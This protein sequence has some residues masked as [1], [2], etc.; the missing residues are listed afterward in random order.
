MSDDRVDPIDP[1]LYRHDDV[2]RI[3]AGWDI[4]A[5]FRFL[6][7]HAGLTQRQIAARTGQNQ[8]E[9]AEILAGRRGPVVNHHVLRRLA[10]G[11]N[12]PPERM[13]LSWWS[14]DGT[15]HGPDG[16]YPEGVTVAGTPEGVSAEMLRR[17]LLALGGV[18]LAGQP[19]K[20]LGE[21][22]ELPSTA[23]EPV[24]LPSRISWVHVTKV[25][26]LRQRLTDLSRA[27]GSDPEASSA[28]VRWAQRLL[29]VPGTE[30]VRR[31]LLVAVA[32]LQVHAGYAGFDAG[33]YERA[34]Y[35]WARA[36]ELATRAGDAY[37]QARALGLA[38]I[39]TVEHG[40]PQ[41]GLKM[42]QCAQVKSWDI[43]P[44]YERGAVVFPPAAVEACALADSATALELLGEQQAAD[45]AL[46]KS[47]QLW[48]PGRTDPGGD[49]DD[50]GARLQLGRRRLDTAEQYAA[51]SVRRWEGINH[52][53]AR[54]YADILL[55]TVHIRAGERDGLQL[56]HS[57]ITQ[58]TKLSSVRARQQYLSPLAIALE[59]RPGSDAKQLA[60][61]T[62]QVIATRA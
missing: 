11:L 57:A 45:R 37:L 29:S 51:A 27:Y 9:V 55:A 43:P 47:R 39:A 8:S 10:G 6:N 14:P 3:L 41:D 60:Q 48:T 32:E 1:G 23:P 19:V 38:G 56:A 25:R 58:V 28:A 52:Q 53:R 5:L 44:G 12:I 31:A 15:Y 40:H 18:T 49:L 62:R 13:G 24:P 42:L 16:A 36:L 4:A 30:P 54:T 46:G 2:R 26:D 7:D 17:H 20:H 33:L 35:H 50:V 61:M 59:A 34:L 22:L 21:L